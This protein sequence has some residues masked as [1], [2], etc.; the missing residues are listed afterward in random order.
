MAF[1]EAMGDPQLNVV[2]EGVKCMMA[3]LG[4]EMAVDAADALGHEVREVSMRG[5]GSTSSYGKGP[6]PILINKDATPRIKEFVAFHEL[7]H[8][9]LFRNHMANREVSSRQEEVY[10]DAFA[11]LMIGNKM[12]PCPLR[13]QSL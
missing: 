7:G 11:C 4:I 6:N 9:I 13:P 5:L 12:P 1:P 8:Q 3:E 10:C 2:A